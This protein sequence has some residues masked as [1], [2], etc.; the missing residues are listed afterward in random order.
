MTLITI[1][2]HRRECTCFVV[3]LQNS[4]CPKWNMSSLYS[5]KKKKTSVFYY[6]CLVFSIALKK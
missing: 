3:K 2:L 1:E 6:E 5:R 4:H